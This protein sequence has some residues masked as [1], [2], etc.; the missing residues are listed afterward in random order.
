MKLWEIV[1]GGGAVRETIW[2]AMTA[3]LF[4][5][6]RGWIKEL[7]VTMKISVNLW[8]SSSTQERRNSVRNGSHA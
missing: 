4:R 6:V 7:S 2:Q 3:L 1:H 5:M 8:G